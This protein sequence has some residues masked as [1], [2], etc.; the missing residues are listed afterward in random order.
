MKYM[1]FI[2]WLIVGAIGLILFAVF[3]GAGNNRGKFEKAC[4]EAR[5][6]TVFDGRQY[7]CIKP[8]SP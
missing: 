8:Q 1:T 7:Q 5:G 6:T 4:D 2:E 3:I